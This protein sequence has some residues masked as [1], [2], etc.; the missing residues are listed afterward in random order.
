MYFKSEKLFWIFEPKEHFVSDEKII[1]KTEPKTD[2]WQHTYCKFRNDFAPAILI[3]T[4]E[5]YFM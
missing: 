1:I 2:F 3:N 5:Q 4:T